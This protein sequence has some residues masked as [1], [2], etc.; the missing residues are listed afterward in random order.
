MVVSRYLVISAP[1]LRGGGRVRREEARLQMR[2]KRGHAIHSV[3]SR[4]ARLLAGAAVVGG[5]ALASW[6]GRASAASS[7]GLYGSLPS[8]GTPSKGG[9]ISI[10]FLTGSTPLTIFPITGDAQ[11]SVYTS[12]GFQYDFFVPLYNGPV[13][14]TQEIDYAVSLASKP[15]F[16]NGN[17]TVTIN[18]KQGYKWSNGQPVDGNDLVFDIDLMKAAVTE[19]PANLSSYSPGLFPSNVSSISAPSKYTVVIHLTRG[20]N[21]GFF[22]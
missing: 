20:F 10:G 11:S 3:M 9:T 15:T 8:A 14:D 16:S 19:N 7:S 17:K 6:G 4:R 22:L 21:P 13:G 18:M 12:F 2:G 1:G 5:L